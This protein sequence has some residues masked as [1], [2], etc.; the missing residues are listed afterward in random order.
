[1]EFNPSACAG[2]WPQYALAAL[3]HVLLVGNRVVQKHVLE[4]REGGLRPY[5]SAIEA[6]EIGM[7]D[8]NQSL[9]ELVE[10]EYI[11]VRTATEASPNVDE[12]MMKLKKLG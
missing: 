9:V 11:H 6:R 8:F 5:L 7:V 3:E 4:G 1:M 12:L 10:K 2:V